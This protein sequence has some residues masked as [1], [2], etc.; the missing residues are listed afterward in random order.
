MAP[1]KL[2]SPA[3]LQRIATLLDNQYKIPFTSYRIG[4]DFIIGLIPVV[5]DFLTFLVSAYILLA[6]RH[7]PVSKFIW[8]K[9]ILNIVIDFFLG[10][11]PIVGDLAD[12][13]WKANAKNVKLLLQVAEKASYEHT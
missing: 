12:A 7:Y 2:Y 6:A 3:K 9:M 13:A 5:G 11:V 1:G 8:F 10:I 4:W